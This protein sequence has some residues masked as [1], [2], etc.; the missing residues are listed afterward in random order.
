MRRSDDGS[1]PDDWSR[2]SFPLGTRHRGACSSLLWPIF[3]AL[4]LVG[5]EKGWEG[6]SEK[7]F[8]VTDKELT[9]HFSDGMQYQAFK[10]TDKD[11]KETKKAIRHTPFPPGAKMLTFE[12]FQKATLECW[13]KSL[14][15]QAIAGPMMETFMSSVAFKLFGEEKSDAK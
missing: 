15:L 5:D 14:M 10:V 12:D 1:M 7:R 2:N 9:N 11:L 6:M 3:Y 4:A 13:E 8:I